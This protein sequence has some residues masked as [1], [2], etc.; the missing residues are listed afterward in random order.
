M[1]DVEVEGV[2]GQLKWEQLAGEEVLLMVA[3]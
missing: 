2:G 1:E 3:P